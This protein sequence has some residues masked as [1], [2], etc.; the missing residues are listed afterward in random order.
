LTFTPDDGIVVLMSYN[1][2]K[3]LARKLQGAVRPRRARRTPD[4]GPYASLLELAGTAGSEF[5]DVSSRKNEHLGD[6]YARRLP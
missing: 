4:A 2:V 3:E 6:I 1:V 5:R